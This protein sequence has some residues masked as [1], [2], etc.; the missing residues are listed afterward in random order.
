MADRLPPSMATLG[1]EFLTLYDIPHLCPICGRVKEI[2][3]GRAISDELAADWRLTEEQRRFFDF[4][5]GCSCRHCGSSVRRMEMGMAL[6]EVLNLRSGECL[7]FVKDL[8]AWEGAARLKIAEIN[9]CGS[10]HGYLQQLPG[11]VYSEYG[12]QDPLLSSEDLSQLSYGDD[13]FDLV[14][15]SDVLEHVPDYRQA[16]AESRR[17]LKADGVLVFTVPFL[18]DRPTVRRAVLAGGEVRHLCSPS[19]HGEYRLR[20]G[21]YL[22]YHEFGHDFVEELAGYF[23]TAVYGYSG[24]SGSIS[25]VFVCRR[26]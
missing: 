4:R 24:Y 6:L 22:V 15:H 13:S 8:P 5:E 14:L 19:Y 17:V 23:D 26:R 10:L 12:S 1:K 3:Q 11:L 2:A 9:N 20:L 25:S 21:D 18:L 16:L 7:Q